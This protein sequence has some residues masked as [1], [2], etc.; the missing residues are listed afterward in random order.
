M[1]DE[2]IQAGFEAMTVDSLEFMQQVGVTNTMAN[3][4][5]PESFAWEAMQQQW[6]VNQAYEVFQTD[7]E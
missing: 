5:S 4:V 3:G 6:G 1:N 2:L 7:D